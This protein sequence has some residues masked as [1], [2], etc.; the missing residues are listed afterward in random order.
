MVLIGYSFLAS[1]SPSVVRASVMIV[2]HLYAKVRHLRYDLGSASFVVLLMILLKNPMQLFHT[3]LQMSFLAVLTL[4]AAAPFFRK[5]YQGI[6]LSS[7]VVQLGLLPYTAYVFNYVSLAAV[8][9]N[10][11]II[12]LAGFLVPLGTE[13]CPEPDL[14]GADCGI[15]RGP[16]SQCCFQARYRN[17]GT[18]YRRIVWIVDKLQQY[19]LYQRVSHHLK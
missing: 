2:L 16:C 8:F 4:S 11:P 18:G 9:I 15:R 1:F 13:I 12:F 17:H 3:G 6:F 10:V 5:F 14:A 7:G 19:D